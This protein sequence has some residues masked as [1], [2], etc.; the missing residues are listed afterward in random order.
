MH[1]RWY[2][3]SLTFLSDLNIL[4]SEMICAWTHFGIL[5]PFT[6]EGTDWLSGERNENIGEFKASLFSFHVTFCVTLEDFDI[7]NWS[8]RWTLVDKTSFGYRLNITRGIL[9]IFWFF[10][11]IEL[12][13]YFNQLSSKYHSR[14]TSQ[15]TIN[16]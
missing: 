2:V 9:Q 11:S 6:K 1:F 5:K 13:Y 12:N 7:K 10:I 8:L 3:E 4:V 15:R 16:N 14:W